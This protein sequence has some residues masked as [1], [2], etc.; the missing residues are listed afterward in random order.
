MILVDVELLQYLN[1]PLFLKMKTVN[2]ER[3]EKKRRR[4]NDDDY[5]I[6]GPKKCFHSMRIRGFKKTCDEEYVNRKDDQSYPN[7]E[8]KKR[9]KQ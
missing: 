9:R 3:K 4:N 7:N 8:D 1:R 5:D 2:Y 6:T